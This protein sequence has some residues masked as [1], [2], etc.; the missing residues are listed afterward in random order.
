MLEK[1]KACG[2]WLLGLLA[3]LAAVLFGANAL[4]SRKQAQGGGDVAEPAGKAPMVEAQAKETE[5][6]NTKVEEINEVKPPVKT[7]KD[8]NME[9]MLEDYDRL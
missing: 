5:T 4:R 2:S 8:K 9:A 7:P 6:V 3:L 1:L